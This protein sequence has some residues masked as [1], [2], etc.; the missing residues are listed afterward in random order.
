MR[1]TLYNMSKELYDVSCDLG[2][3]L[4]TRGMEF[5]KCEWLKGREGSAG[6]SVF[7]VWRL[8]LEKLGYQGCAAPALTLLFLLIGLLQVCELYGSS[9]LNR[10]LLRMVSDYPLFEY[11]SS[12]SAGHHMM[13]Y[14]W[15]YLLWNKVLTDRSWV[16]FQSLKYGLKFPQSQQMQ[17]C[18]YES[19]L[20][21][22]ARSSDVS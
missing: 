14:W 6:S 16:F 2:G 12:T 5:V 13:S 21:C 17:L 11:L 10:V 15:L 19:G 4:Q 8:L 18:S 7:E 3:A 9:I 1:R 22:F 20:L